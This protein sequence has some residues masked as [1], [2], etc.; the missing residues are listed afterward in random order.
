M[1]ETTTEATKTFE[2]RTM[3]DSQIQTVEAIKSKAATLWDA[4]NDIS[5]PS[6]NTEAGRLVSSA[7][8]TLEES[9]MWA[10]KAISRQ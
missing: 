7:K 8:T 1:T 9:I 6:G 4:L 3:N 2:H 5:V 10:T